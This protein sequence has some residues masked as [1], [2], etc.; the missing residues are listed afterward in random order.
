MLLLLL[1]SLSLLLTGAAAGF[2]SSSSSS[3][4]TGM[5]RIVDGT[6]AVESLPESFASGFE[7]WVLEAESG[8]FTKVPREDPFVNAVTFEPLYLAKDLPRPTHRLALGIHLRDGSLRHLM[9]AVD[10]FVAKEGVVYRNRGLCTVPRAQTWINF[11]G[12]ISIDTLRLVAFADDSSE[13]SAEVEAAE[14]ASRAISALADAPP[15]LFESGSHIIHVATNVELEFS[16]R[17]RV[18]LADF[19]V[20]SPD[21]LGVDSGLLSVVVDDDVEAG[22]DSEFLPE[23]YRPLF[24]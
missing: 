8:E 14:V 7:T 10:S 23:C 2:C 13:R 6:G 20:E 18:G 12:A 24:T 9:P 15:T 16:K 4:S 19:E 17:L 21:Q 11:R 5:V 1:V 3:R 22:A